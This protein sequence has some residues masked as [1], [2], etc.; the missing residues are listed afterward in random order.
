MNK[1]RKAYKSIGEVA[2]DLSI[3]TH[4]LRFW[5]KNLNKSNH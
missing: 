4:T 5:E 3:K 1:D 2:K